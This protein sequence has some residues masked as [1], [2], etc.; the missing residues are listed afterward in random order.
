[1]EKKYLRQLYGNES[2]DTK[3]AK[4]SNVTQMR[5]NGRAPT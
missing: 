3:G 5:D 4:V 2:W 1:M